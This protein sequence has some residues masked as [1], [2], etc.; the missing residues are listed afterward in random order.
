MAGPEF[1]FIGFRVGPG[2]S[3]DHACVSAKLTRRR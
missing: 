3:S 1:E 2:H